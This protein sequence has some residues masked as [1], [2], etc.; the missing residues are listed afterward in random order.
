MSINVIT[1]SG[2]VSRPVRRVRGDGGHL[3]VFPLAVRDG[4]DRLVFPVVVLAGPPPS[5]V[6]Y[7]ADKKLHEQPLVTVVGRVCTRDVTRPLADELAAQAR[8]AGASQELVAAIRDTLAELP[9]T[10]RRVVTE[11]VAQAIYEGGV[12]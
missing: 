2:R 10:S 1:V 9:L 8:R 7:H 4:A 12:W 3:Y 6:A 11:I 5:F